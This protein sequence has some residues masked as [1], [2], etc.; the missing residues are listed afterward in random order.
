MTSGYQIQGADTDNV[1][2]VTDAPIAS[3]VKIF[4]VRSVPYEQTLSI[5]NGDNFNAELIEKTFDSQEMQIQQL[6]EQI[7]RAVV[8]SLD[9]NE[10]LS[11]SGIM[12]IIDEAA[13]RSEYFANLAQTIAN[14]VHTEIGDCN[15]RQT[16]V[17]T[18]A[19]ESGSILTLPIYYYPGRDDLLLWYD[20]VLCQPKKAI[21]GDNP[22]NIF[23]YEEV[24]MPG[25]EWSNKITL[26]FGVEEGKVLDEFV[27]ST[28]LIRRFGEIEA[29]VQA[30]EDASA[31]SKSYRDQAEALKNDTLTIKADAISE[32]GQL[33][34]SALEHA[35]AASG[36]AT[37]A[38]TSAGEAEQTANDIRE[39]LDEL[40]GGGGGGSGSA[41]FRI[42]GLNVTGNQLVLYESE[43]S[44]T[45]DFSNFDYVDFI[46][47]NCSFILESGFLKLKMV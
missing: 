2:V 19:I 30:S 21:Y 44:D 47:L 17:A 9:N 8:R 41:A 18:Q 23:E 45:I 20:G 13:A 43:D 46:P 37:N 42:V 3:G 4:I 12:S 38:A 26:L 25:H 27:V 11:V 36:Y 40:G 29:L 15:G 14:S 33:K 1:N 16:W 39:I 35:Q 6:A 28:G 7:S 31:S 5:Q 34:N 24:V 32:V 22:P 10:Q